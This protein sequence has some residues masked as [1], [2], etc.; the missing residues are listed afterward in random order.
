M[1]LKLLFTLFT[2]L[3]VFN[4]FRLEFI[5]LFLSFNAMPFIHM[6]MH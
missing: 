5:L 1:F 4:M 3:F 2:R 6:S